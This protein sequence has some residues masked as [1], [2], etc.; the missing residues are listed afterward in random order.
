MPQIELISIQYRNKE[1]IFQM[2]AFDGYRLIILEKGNA[3][4]QTA[5][6]I[7]PF[8]SA[9][10]F[11]MDGNDPAVL[12]TDQEKGE[13]AFY[14]I[15]FSLAG[16][17]ISQGSCVY[18][19]NSFTIFYTLARQLVSIER[20]RTEDSASSLY[21]EQQAA[22]ARM[23]QQLLMNIDEKKESNKG[24]SE[25]LRYIH[26]HYALPMNREMLAKIANMSVSRYAHQFKEIYGIAPVDYLNETRLKH[27]KLLLK[28]QRATIQSVAEKSGFSDVFYF[29]R[30]FKKQYGISPSIYMRSHHLKV[31]SLNYQ[32]TGDLQAVGIQPNATILDVYRPWYTDSKLRQQHSLFLHRDNRLSPE[33][34]E[35][36]TKCLAEV[37]P[38]VIFCTPYEVKFYD[39]EE[40][41]RIAPTVVI[42]WTDMCWREHL[43]C[44][45]DYTGRAEAAEEWLRRYDD[46]VYDVMNQTHKFIGK[47]SLSIFHI[48]RG[49]LVVYGN[50]NGGAVFFNELGI[51]PA[52]SLERIAVYQ[53][54]DESELEYY[55]GDY[56]VLCVDNNKESML[57]YTQLIGGD[58]WRSLKAIC[59]HRVYILCDEP[60]VDYCALA[61]DSV[62]NKV[63]E[64][65]R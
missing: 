23:M 49:E 44:L 15:A 22:L 20:K 52:Y 64:L 5:S 54:V 11:F 55:A 19:Q 14:I 31:A 1:E 46:S 37:K 48:I 51:E 30:K 33:T 9:Q 35:H 32:L 3:R 18:D 38:D 36:N 27:A 53:P 17:T 60:W 4:L 65:F 40:L 63:Q 16:E 12:M 2:E 8:Y 24:V 59:N 56:I 57:R 39:L 62:L 13:C 29:S 26:A 58:T 41:M 10:S 21:W 61:H 50:R 47:H 25:T 6:A 45:A 34:V 28:S 42:P 43:R 7:V